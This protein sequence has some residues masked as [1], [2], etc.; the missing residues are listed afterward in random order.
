MTYKT[1]EFCVTKGEMT[2]PIDPA[3]RHYQEILDDVIAQGADCWDGDIPESI[4]ADA[5]AKLFA[6]QLSDYKRAMKRLAQYTLATGQEEVTEQQ[7]GADEEWNESTGEMEPVMVSVV[8][9][10]AIEPIEATIEVSEADANGNV[11]TTTI[12]NPLITQDNAERA[13]AQAVVDATPQAV[14]DAYNEE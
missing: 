8:V 10:K 1:N 2:I 9:Q 6:Q 12:D 3:N 14:I 13:E 5:D 11:T 7:Q 4:Q